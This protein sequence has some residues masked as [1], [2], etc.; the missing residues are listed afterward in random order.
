ML[1]ATGSVARECNVQV[2]LIDLLCQHGADPNTAIRP[3]AVHEHDALRALIR[4]GARID[5]P[6]AAALNLPSAF[7]SLLPTAIP[8]DRHLAL[9][10]AAQFGHLDRVRALLHAGEG[11]NRYNPSG[12]HS[13]ATP[14]HLAAGAGN[15][16]VIR[17]LVERGARLDL[18]DV[19]WNATPA[20]WAAHEAKAEVERFLREREAATSSIAP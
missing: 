10:L 4:N 13:H 15:E 14:L 2:P 11:P 6:V 17:L 20:D 19:L 1:V 18:T 9:A 3:A 8:A 7:D 16:A 5:L 12:G